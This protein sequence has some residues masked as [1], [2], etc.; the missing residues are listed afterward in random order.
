MDFTERLNLYLEGGMIQP[1]DVADVQAIITMF[2]QKYH[3]VLQEENADTFIA[4]SYTHLDV[5]KRQKESPACSSR[6]HSS[7]S[8]VV[9]IARIHGRCV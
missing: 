5:Y 3:I 9:I 1:D 2:D 6:A 7:K 8:C 4:V